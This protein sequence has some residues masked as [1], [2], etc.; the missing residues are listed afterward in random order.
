M[1]LLEYGSLALLVATLLLLGCR[2]AP[3]PVWPESLSN[4]TFAPTPEFLQ[5]RR[6]GP[7]RFSQVDDRLYRGGQ[8]TDA[9]LDALKAFGVDTILS[10]RDEGTGR[11]AAERRHAEEIGLRFVH[12]PFSALSPVKPEV[13]DRVLATLRDPASGKVYIH[14]HIGRDRTSL[15]VALHLAV[16]RGW[17]PNLAWQRAVLDY[18]H[19]PTFWFRSLSA[20]FYR[21]TFQ[22]RVDAEALQK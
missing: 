8:P 21:T 3:E 2:S 18:G 13:I 14:C 17:E 16:N 20:A 1:R 7:T 11:T 19:R 22:H 10:L 12:V 9:Q 5:L 4:E 15:M 6:T